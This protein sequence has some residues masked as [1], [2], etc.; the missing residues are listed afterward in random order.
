MN[1]PD[2][3]IP[4]NLESL[5]QP[6]LRD[7]LIDLRHRIHQ[8]PE[9]AWHEEQTVV[10]LE[11]ALSAVGIDDFQRVAQTGLVAR[12]RGKSGGP[13]I[14][15]RADLDALPVQ[16]ETGLPYAS[17]VPG[18]MHA[19]G[20]DVHA[21]WAIGAAA[22]L[23]ASPPPGDVL[24]VLQPAEEQGNGASAILESGLLDEAQAIFGAHVDGK[25]ALG[26]VVAQAGP[27]AASTDMFEITLTGQGAHGARPQEGR[28]PIV[29]AA[30]LVTAL[31]TIVSR[32]VNPAS[33]AVVTVG[34]LQAGTAANVIPDRAILAGTLRAID[35]AVRDLLL[36]EVAILAENIARAF[37]LTARVE[38][39]DGSTPP[40]INSPEGAGWAA[41]A[42]E[43]IL[44]PGAA[45]P[46]A[47]PN[48]GGEDFSFYLERMTGAFL[49]IGIITPGGDPVAAHTARF[50]VPDEAIFVGSAVLAQAVRAER[51]QF[52]EL[53]DPRRVSGN[54][55]QVGAV[56][57]HSFL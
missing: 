56:F 7:L 53:P 1:R 51:L 28:D 8:N 9:L 23:Q 39:L 48:L 4:G 30:A 17:Q 55:M 26:L 47:E 42:A 43:D 12:I 46:L 10:A 5:F 33:P 14:A 32:R 45:V 18:I 52:T 15:I 19:C 11:K 16:E 3:H 34:R 22:L 50:H 25:I 31:Q 6:E 57:F 41:Q 36:S 44:G 37:G 38:F 13:V 24:V 21:A 29:G 2:L 27:V 35:Q 40:I 20:H 54:E 49:R